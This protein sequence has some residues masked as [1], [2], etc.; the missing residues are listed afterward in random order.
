MDQPLLDEFTKGENVT[1]NGDKLAIPDLSIEQ[2]REQINRFRI[3]KN[4]Y[5]PSVCY[6]LGRIRGKIKLRRQ[7]CNPMSA[8]E[9]FNV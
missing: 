5:N 1:L 2:M 8:E 3:Y 7:R 4:E 6:W 9:A